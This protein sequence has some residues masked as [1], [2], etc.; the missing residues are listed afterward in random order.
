MF[1]QFFTK[2]KTTKEVVNSIVSSAGES[3]LDSDG[4]SKDTK[5]MEL[6][7]MSR[8]KFNHQALLESQ[9]GPGDG[10]NKQSH[11]FM[12]DDEE[13]P[14]DKNLEM[15][16]MS[17]MDDINLGGGST[18]GGQSMTRDGSTDAL[19]GVHSI[20]QTQLSSIQGGNNSFIGS[21]ASLNPTPTNQGHQG[22]TN[23]N[24]FPTYG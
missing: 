2:P 18:I 8:M 22:Y 13:N 10:K 11:S 17:G 6:S 15:M 19:S 1:G 20:H 12:T 16:M 7:E 21:I 4:T 23:Q 3:D 9:H 5:P 14:E 24:N